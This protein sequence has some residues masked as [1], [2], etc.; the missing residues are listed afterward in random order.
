MSSFVDHEILLWNSDTEVT[1]SKHIVHLGRGTDEEE[2]TIRKVIMGSTEIV[3]YCQ[4]CRYS[5]D[6]KYR[7]E[8][9]VFK[10]GRNRETKDL[11]RVK[12]LEF[13]TRTPLML[14]MNGLNLT[15]CGLSFC[16]PHWVK[17]LGY[18]IECPGGVWLFMIAGLALY[19]IP[20]RL[21]W[22][23]RKAASYFRKP[24]T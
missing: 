22:L 1:T 7:G 19:D 11:F 9:W 8:I 18:C 16:K 6:M 17:I 20:R 15:G 4:N 23:Y 14:A 10:Y 2:A 13:L 3:M 12:A 21:S 5:A 24:K